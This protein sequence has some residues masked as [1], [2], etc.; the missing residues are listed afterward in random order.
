MKKLYFFLISII[1]INVGCSRSD[2][3]FIE[4]I[5]NYV[6]ENAL[7]LDLKYKSIDFKL[8]DTVFVKDSLKTL[9]KEYSEN[10][11]P[12][13]GFK[14][15]IKDDFKDGYIYTK[16]YITEKR[17]SELRNWELNIGHPSYNEYSGQAIWVADGFKDYYEFAF[18]NRNASEFISSLCTQVEKTDSLLKVFDKVKNG[19]LELINN[20]NWYYKRIDKFESSEDPDKNGVFAKVD[21][22]VA[23]LK[24]VKLSIDSLSKLNPEN[25]IQYKAINTYQ[26]NNPL[27]NGAEQKITR[28]FN[29]NPEFKVIPEK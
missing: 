7:G 28:Q 14:F 25:I 4:S 19:D 2:S 16:D 9:K 20:V 24:N 15:Y 11:K 17:F 6:N 21:E 29:F 23:Y 13:L 22:V 8:I 26:I 5:N 18:S 12:L 27:F 3:V 1:S 10:I